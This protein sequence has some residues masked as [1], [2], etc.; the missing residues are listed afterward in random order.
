MILFAVPP[1]I[2]QAPD[3]LVAPAG[4]DVNITCLFTG[5]PQPTIKWCT[6]EKTITPNKRYQ[7]ESTS[8]SST[9][10]LKAA[11]VSDSATYVI[12]LE[13]SVGKATHSISV[14]ITSV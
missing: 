6:E 10:T 1:K 11:D 9:F 12:I 8:E 14:E 5:K 2:T 3:K 4:E 13:N 7:I